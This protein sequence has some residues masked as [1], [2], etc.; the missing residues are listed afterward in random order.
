M[1]EQI[2]PQHFIEPPSFSST[3]AYHP[4]DSAMNCSAAV[5]PVNQ[6]RAVKR[7]RGCAEI[8]ATYS[9]DCHQTD[10]SRR[11]KNRH[12]SPS[13][14]ALP[15]RKLTAPKHVYDEPDMSTLLLLVFITVELL[16]RSRVQV[17]SCARPTKALV[18]SS[19]EWTFHGS[20]S[21]RERETQSNIPSWRIR[22][23]LDVSMKNQSR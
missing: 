15:D 8:S 11:N 14:P 22:S 1:Q 20:K 18:Q 23:A 16:R 19:P 13:G 9:L 17:S 6:N 4:L 7:V 3:L 10:L 5:L 2:Q 12:S 21:D